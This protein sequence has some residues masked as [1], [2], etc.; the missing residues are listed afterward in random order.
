MVKGRLME[1]E[2]VSEAVLREEIALLQEQ[3]ARVRATLG[4]L[5]EE[6]ARREQDYMTLRSEAMLEQR[7]ND[8][9]E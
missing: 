2:R 6:R 5:A 7:I 4:R 1:R 3:E 8:D 9:W